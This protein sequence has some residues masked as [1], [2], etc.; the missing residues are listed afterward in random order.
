M[1]KRIRIRRFRNI[2]D[3]NVELQSGVIALSGDNA[4]GKSSFLEAIHLLGYLNGFRNR[5]DKELINYEMPSADVTGWIEDDEETDE[6]RV[7]ITPNKKYVKVNGTNI[8]RFEDYYGRL[9]VHLF[10]PQNL[11][12]VRGEP[13]E[14]RQTLDYLIVRMNPKM[15]NVFTEFRKS[16]NQRNAILKRMRDGGKTKETQLLIAEWERKLIS[17]GVTITLERNLLCKRLIES[18]K[19]LYSALAL[20]DSQ[21][22]IKFIPNIPSDEKTQTNFADIYQSVLSERLDQDI[23]VGFTTCGPQR[24]ELSFLLDG[25]NLKVFG[26]QGQTRS[27][28]QAFK[29]ACCL[30]ESESNPNVILCL[31]DALAELDDKRKRNLLS[32][33][34][35]YRFC[36]AKQV[37][38]TVVAASDMQLLRDLLTQQIKI[39][40]GKLVS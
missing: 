16:L 23:R 5:T 15:Y 20:S 7:V 4:Q 35:D 30:L 24:D 31:D 9:P 8:T 33:L 13:A 2:G 37:F 1:L 34:Q 26:S 18:I 3:L 21:L 17:S 25:H 36:G 32:V 19:Q 6:L 12:L 11:E 38:I 39:A 29:L 27:A 28:V 10:V 14:R 40:G 22:A